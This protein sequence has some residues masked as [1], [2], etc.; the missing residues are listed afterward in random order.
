MASVGD[1]EEEEEL[2]D[3]VEEEGFESRFGVGERV[4]ERFDEGGR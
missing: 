3:H 2:D 1:E 4:K